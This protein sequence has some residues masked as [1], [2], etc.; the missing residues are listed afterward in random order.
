MEKRLLQKPFIIFIFLVDYFLTLSFIS[1][2]RKFSLDLTDIFTS[3]I[4]GTNRSEKNLRK[5]EKI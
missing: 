3:R 2:K 5:K 4:I 1:L